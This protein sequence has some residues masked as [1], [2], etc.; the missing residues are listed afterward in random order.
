[1]Q[2]HA[3]EDDVWCGPCFRIDYGKTMGA[4]VAATQQCIMHHLSSFKI[5]ATKKFYIARHHNP[6]E[7]LEFPLKTKGWKQMTS[8]LTQT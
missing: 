8:L 1:M 7:L 4:K 6:G 3:F 5:E 2:E